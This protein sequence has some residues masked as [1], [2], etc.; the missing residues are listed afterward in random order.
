MK[1]VA[2]THL[3][4]LD[5]FRGLS[6]A[7]MILVNNPGD[8]SA[9]A[10]PLQHAAW[11]GVT[12][13]DL[14][15]PSFLFIMGVT[16]PIAFARRRGQGHTAWPLA[17]RIVR[18]GSLLL[19][20]G[21][22]LNLAASW[23]WSDPIRVT[24][25][26][27]RI[28]LTY[29]TA[30]VFV[31]N[32]DIGGLA[33]AAAVLLA[34]HW[35]L[36]TLVPFGGHAAGTMTPDDNLARFLDAR[37]LG[38]HSIARGTDPEG[39]LGTT[40]ATANVLLGAVAGHVIARAP[41][42]ARAWVRLLVG[43]T[44]LIALGTAWSLVLPLGK[45]LWTGSFALFTTGVAACALAVFY[46]VVDVG[47]HRVWARPLVWLGVNPLAIYCLSEAVGHALERPWGATG[48]MATT[49]KARL[50]W[51]ALVPAMRPLSVSTAS[52][53]FAAVCALFWVGVAGV[54]YRLR[55][56]IRV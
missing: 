24:G 52:L 37:L 41:D 7:A 38:A 25:I 1:G 3:E 27:Q 18:R 2:A 4:S 55:I 11:T 42:L 46:V 50:V 5:A 35:M 51:G 32:A 17:L 6:I 29:V 23:P 40:S 49:L 12:L 36:L 34:G 16:M 30:S 8:W 43:G 56:R 48:A 10:A 45:P 22:V 26:L 44:L 47:G 28:A 9:V 53:V 21:V 19:V 39:L 15:F 31:I 14:V 54:L 20:L 13:A 33:L